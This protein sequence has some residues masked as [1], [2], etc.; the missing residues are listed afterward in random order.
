MIDL[1]PIKARLAAAT[2]GPWR[3]YMNK[4]SRDIRLEAEHSGRLIVMDF[5]RWGMQGAQPRFRTQPHDLMTEYS[6]CVPHADAGL[7]AHT[8]TDIA[9]LVEEIECLRMALDT[10]GATIYTQGRGTKMEQGLL[11]LIRTALGRDK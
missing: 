10:V 4:R 6:D 3:W 7:I 9:A 11:A 5:V 2:P 8:P 1:E